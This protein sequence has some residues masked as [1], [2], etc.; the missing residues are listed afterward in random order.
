MKPTTPL[1]PSPTP[2]FSSIEE[3]IEHIWNESMVLEERFYKNNS[4][5]VMQQFTMNVLKIQ[6]WESVSLAKQREA[7]R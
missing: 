5:V 4:D 2:L 3:L 7:L 6:F 1:P